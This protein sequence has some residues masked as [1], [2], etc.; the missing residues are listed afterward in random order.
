MEGDGR[1]KYFVDSKNRVFTYD[2]IEQMEKFNPGLIEISEAE[3]EELLK[4]TAEQLNA[5]RIS[6]I[7]ARFSEI[8]SESIR[9][10]RAISAGTATEYDTTKLNTLEAERATLAAELVA[11]NG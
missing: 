10:L 11:L 8:D 7:K 2:S 3:K 1:V 5:Q 4:P 6:E 9:P